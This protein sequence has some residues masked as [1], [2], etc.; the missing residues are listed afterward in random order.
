MGRKPK[1]E[2]GRLHN[3]LAV[4]R[5]ERRLT[6]QQLADSLGVNYQTVGYLERGDYSPSLELAFRLSEF[7]GLPIEAIFA[8]EPFT[9][10]SEQVYAEAE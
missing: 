6:R 4:L 5:A 10:M 8:R 7:F 3:R 1:G 9:P 2:E